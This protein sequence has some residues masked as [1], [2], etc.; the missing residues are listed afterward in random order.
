MRT[1]STPK[2]KS[3]GCWQTVLSRWRSPAEAASQ[4]S[5][6]PLAVH[7]PPTKVLG[8][9]AGAAVAAGTRGSEEGA[10]GDTANTSTEGEEPDGADAAVAV[11]AAV[12]EGEGGP[13][14]TQPA[15]GR[16]GG[17]I[18]TKVGKSGCE[19]SNLNILPPNGFPQCFIFLIRLVHCNATLLAGRFRTRVFLFFSGAGSR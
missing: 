9:E 8:T 10:T 15:S 14:T 12:A 18:P 5:A 16:T 11:A 1:R 4:G 13:P 2:R 3:T 7:Q 19:T 17:A 6:R